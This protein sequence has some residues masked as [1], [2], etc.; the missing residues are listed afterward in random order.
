MPT[1]NSDYSCRDVISLCMFHPGITEQQLHDV[2]AHCN[3]SMYSG[4]THRAALQYY[5]SFYY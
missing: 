5:Y 1:C 2:T 4:I 3:V